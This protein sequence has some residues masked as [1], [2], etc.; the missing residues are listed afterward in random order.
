MHGLTT[1]KFILHICI[2]LVI[3]VY[4]IMLYGNMSINSLMFLC[5]LCNRPYCCCATAVTTTNRIL[6]R[7]IMVILRIQWTHISSQARASLS[8]LKINDNNRR[9]KR[10]NAQITNHILAKHTH[11]IVCNTVYVNGDVI[12]SLPLLLLVSRVLWYC[13]A[14]VS[15]IILQLQQIAKPSNSGKFQ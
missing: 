1:P 12:I 4:Y 9:K 15:Y 13:C 14:R 7:I 3:F 10:I 8:N 11:K 2:L 5:C 6:F